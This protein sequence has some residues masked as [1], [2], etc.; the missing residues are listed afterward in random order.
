MTRWGSYP[1]TRGAYAAARP[2]RHKARAMLTDPLGDRVFFAGEALGGAYPALLS[3]AHI[4][5]DAAAR[6]V[7]S[8]LAAIKN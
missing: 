8:I 7:A 5:G 2:G 1:W 4:S 3:G 6:R